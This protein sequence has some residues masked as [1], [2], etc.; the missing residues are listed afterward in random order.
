M[1]VLLDKILEKNKKW[2]SYGKVASYIPELAK[3]N[4]NALGIYIVDS[5]NHEYFSGDYDIKFTIQSISKIITFIS[6]LND[7]PFS[8]ISKIISVEPSSDAFDSIANLETN[9]TH[10]PLNPM[11]NA[12]A[13]ATISFVKG[14]TYEHKFRRVFEFAK[15]ITG[16]PNLSVNKA[17]FNSERLTGN[18]NRALAYFMKSTGIINC[19]VEEI[20]DVYFKLCSIDVTCKDV[21]R[22][23]MML[24]ND[25]VLIQNDEKVTSKEI[26]HIVKAVM[27]TCGMY[28]DSG[29]FATSVGIPAKSGV[30]GG[31]LGVVPKRMGI[32]IVGPALN[33][34]GNS[35]AGTKILESLSNQLELSIY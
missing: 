23:G 5:K 22:I 4:P 34:K 27:C 25:G 9:S 26:C 28:N 7:S 31:I 20:L 1:Q 19:E 16:N 35:I 24:A 11:I 14:E 3:A 32:G 13:I 18:K 30:G 33:Q 8:E 2:T 15:K 21:A 29:E 6:A 17:V 12:G 10:K